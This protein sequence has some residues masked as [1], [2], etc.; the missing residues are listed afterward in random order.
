MYI[1]TAFMLN[2]SNFS[3][4]RFFLTGIGLLSVLLGA[5]IAI[6]LTS[7]IGFP[8][9]PHFSMLPFLMVGLGIDDMFVIMQVFRNLENIKE[10]DIEE[11]ISSTLRYAGVAIT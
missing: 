2:G 9:M 3:D 7:A 4:M 8:Y 11:K 6:G 5:A 1:Y 10:A